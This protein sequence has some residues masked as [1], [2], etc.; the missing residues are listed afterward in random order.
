V[1][2]PE[3]EPGH[4]RGITAIKNSGKILKKFEE[5]EATDFFKESAGIFR[6][7]ESLN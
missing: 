1:P 7:Q 4:Q 2:G 5:L 6:N 3:I